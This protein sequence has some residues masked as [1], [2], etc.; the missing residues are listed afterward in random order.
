MIIS[1]FIA[2]AIITIA[3]LATGHNSV[4]VTGATSA[5]VGLCTG[6]GFYSKGKSSGSKGAEKNVL[7]SSDK[8][9]AKLP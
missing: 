7:Q 6:F 4:I 2:V 9:A 8:P 3:A 5:I 1:A